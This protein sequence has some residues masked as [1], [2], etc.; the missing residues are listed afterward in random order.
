MVLTEAIAYFMNNGSAVYSTTLDATKAFDR[1]DY[2]KMF[3]L[4]VGHDL[5]S[6]W[7]RLLVN[8][9]TNS[10]TRIA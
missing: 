3:R 9:Y 8:I 5:P 1:V 2:C 10:S 4:L 7:L 6:A